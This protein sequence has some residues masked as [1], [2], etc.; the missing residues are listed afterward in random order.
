MINKQALLRQIRNAYE[1]T[2][3][4]IIGVGFALKEVGNT[5]TDRKSIVFY[6]REKK[7]LDQLKQDEILPNTIS[8]AGVDYPCD[9]VQ[10][11]PFKALNAC[12]DNNN[13]S[14]YEIAR[15]QGQTEDGLLLPMRGGQEIFIF[16]GGWDAYG[17]SSL[18]TLGFF[19]IDNTDDRV[20]GVT[21][22]HVVVENLLFAADPIRL[23]NLT[24]PAE[25]IQ[26]NPYN[27]IEPRPW[28]VT[29][30]YYSAGCLVRNGID[31]HHAG[32][33]IKRYT[34]YSTQEYN[35]VDA[36]L[37]IMND[38]QFLGNGDYFVDASSYQIWQPSSL[39]SPHTAH[40]PF[41]TTEEIDDLV[42]ARCYSTGRTT[43]PKGYCDTIPQSVLQITGVHVTSTI[44]FSQNVAVEFAD[45]IQYKASNGYEQ[46]YRASLPGDSGSA[47][48]ADVV[49]PNNGTTTRKIV[50]VVFAGNGTI[51]LANRID[52]V[53]QML[54]IRAW[55]STYQFTRS[56]SLSVPT[57]RIITEP[58]EVAG[59]E[60]H[61]TRDEQKYWH[62]GLSFQ[63][64]YIQWAPTDITLTNNSIIETA[65]GGQLI[66]YFDTVDND[67]WDNFVYTLV[68]GEGDED[69]ASFRIIADQLQVGFAAN[70]DGEE[71]DP[72]WRRVTFLL[73][74]QYDCN[75]GSGTLSDDSLTGKL[76]VPTGTAQLV[77]PIVV[78]SNTSYP[79]PKPTEE[80]WPSASRCGFGFVDIGDPHYISV[81]GSITL[82]GDFTLECW[83]WPTSYDTW[84]PSP[85]IEGQNAYDDA[86]RLCV[87]LNY[88]NS[89][90]VFITK[91]AN[92]SEWG[93]TFVTTGVVSGQSRA[94]LPTD[95]WSH[96]AI[97]RQ[98]DTV[99]V[100]LNGVI[101]ETGSATGPIKF[102]NAKLFARR[103]VGY[104]A[105]FRVTTVARYSGASFTLPTAPF[106]QVGPTTF[107]Y[108]T[109]S[110]YSIRVRSTDSGG[111]YFEKAFTINV[112]NAIEYPPTD[113][114]AK[115]IDDSPPPTSIYDD[116]GLTEPIWKF[117]TVDQ[118]TNDS[119][120]YDLVPG[121]G[122]THNN[123][124][125]IGDLDRLYRNGT[126]SAGSTYSIRVRSTDL[127]DMSV[128]KVFT[129][130]VV[131]APARP[132]FDLQRDSEF[133]NS[134]TNLTGKLAG[135]FYITSKDPN[136]TYDQIT[137]ALYN[138]T[139]NFPHNAL[140]TID[141]AYNDGVS[142]V[143]QARLLAAT[144]ITTSTFPSASFFTI[145]VRGTDTRTGRYT[146]Q[147][148]SIG[149]SFPQAPYFVGFSDPYRICWDGRSAYTQNE[150]I[151]LLDIDFDPEST[152]AD[153]TAEF[154]TTCTGV[155]LSNSLFSLYKNT[156]ANK[157]ELRMA[158]NFDFNTGGYTYGTIYLCIKLTDTRTNLTNTSLG[159][160]FVGDCS[161]GGFSS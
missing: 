138:P 107:D 101:Y 152:F 143:N 8:I 25:V 130:A 2:S 148:F 145:N 82:N 4:N 115:S 135:T 124:F 44:G 69:N 72:Y 137:F 77:N 133:E 58:V 40:Y 95:R 32:L 144:D 92:A 5:R 151:T 45:L 116:I 102:Q 132:F 33:N 18:G 156:M 16:P 149:R 154:T 146:D 105:D 56:T 61:V 106:A 88:G 28:P 63:Q 65:Y 84:Q 20:V 53:A 117:T 17:G 141:N 127:G 110:E 155:T 136:S 13:Q 128:E 140:F 118:D 90:G 30:D 35:Y 75:V 52:R 86:S 153:I 131:Q 27:T 100:Y 74:A 93:P 76:V 80:K 24:L 142:D 59:E 97:V 125:R 42:G 7:P 123:L 48:L 68:E 21:N 98:E 60:L 31:Y 47:L 23:P 55:D 104:F 87:Y 108:E 15:L 111:N 79:S 103:F 66:G 113:I 73:S 11:E 78:S 91:G 121:T 64:Y 43:G 109:K 114:L 37:L 161:G 19:A 29:G 41:A 34:P 36:A 38:G 26:Y 96:L 122:S 112:L 94:K 139:S 14:V 158:N 157:Y 50:G 159:Y 81:D 134:Q 22:T 57:P 129:V 71:E 9:V 51:G 147:S 1:N 49:N 150:I 67:I 6:V 99:R 3:D 46:I 54:D 70:P 120:V 10:T 89:R 126:L 83:L 85:L 39:T 119:F 12:Y 62:A 160:M